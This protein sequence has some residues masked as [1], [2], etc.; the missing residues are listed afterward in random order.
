MMARRVPTV[1]PRSL[2]VVLDA[3]NR[4]HRPTSLRPWVIVAAVAI[5]AL[6]FVVG[7]YM[8]RR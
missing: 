5:A 6:A 4:A 2:R 1:R 8:G 7:R 3:D